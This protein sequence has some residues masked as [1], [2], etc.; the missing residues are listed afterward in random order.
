M[1]GPR[2]TLFTVW[3]DEWDRATSFVYHYLQMGVHHIFIIDN[4]SVHAPPDW[5]CGHQNITVIRETRSFLE[6][7][8][9]IE[10]VQSLIKE[11][12]FG[13]WVIICDADEH[14]ILP[15]PSGRD[16]QAFCA[17]MDA[18]GFEA[19]Y[20]L[21]LDLYPA[22]DFRDTDA[23]HGHHWWFEI[24]SIRF[25]GLQRPPLEPTPMHVGGMRE[26]VFGLPVVLDKVPL[27]RYTDHVTVFGGMH[28]IKGARIA[29]GQ[30][31]V[32]HFKFLKGFE[33]RCRQE[34]V[35]KEHWKSA[36]EYQA[37]LEGIVAGKT[38]LKYSDSVPL[39]GGAQQLS[40]YGLIRCNR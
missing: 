27:L 23:I 24:A 16:L 5:I 34:V 25:R 12:A 32:L 38:S 2:V 30:G 22:G 10:W 36:A 39:R 19:L 8:F 20:C 13:E 11:Q 9:G 28:G 17:E 40:E 29:N 31:V 1:R 21:L 37:Y 3:R 18:L 4:L 15:T 26:R 14:L 6:A 35:R 7:R 33:E